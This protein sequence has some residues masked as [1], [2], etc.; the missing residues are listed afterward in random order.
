MPAPT[1]YE[2]RERARLD[3][4][5]QSATE[6][7]LRAR[8]KRTYEDSLNDTSATLPPAGQA[9]ATKPVDDADQNALAS[10]IT[11]P[12][13][14]EAD[15]VQQS[16]ALAQPPEQPA[17]SDAQVVSGFAKRLLR[18]GADTS[19]PG[20]GQA[21]A[22]GYNHQLV[23]GGDSGAA[24]SESDHTAD[25]RQRN[26][27]LDPNVSAR[28]AQRLYAGVAPPRVAVTKGGMIPE[29]STV[30][31]TKGPEAPGARDALDDAYAEAVRGAGGNMA[32]EQE[33]DQRLG[34]VQ[35][36]VSK[37]GE[38]FATEGQREAQNASDKLSAV[39][40]DIQKFINN[41]AVPVET[42]QQA[43][44]KWGA[45]KKIAFVLA[46]ALAGG[47][48]AA[49][50]KHDNAFLDSFN[51]FLKSETDRQAAE[52][53]QKEG[54]AE[55]SK[56]VYWMMHAGFKDDD[57]A[58]AATRAL[59]YQALES[60]LKEA[61]IKY[62]I[63]TSGPR[64]KSLLSQ[65]DTA[66]AHELEQL[67]KLSGA[68]VSQQESQR[69]VP[70]QAV[71]V[72]GGGM[73]PEDIAKDRAFIF[74]GIKDLKINEKA[75]DLNAMRSALMLGDAAKGG[76]LQ[77]YLTAHPSTSFA[78]IVA[79]VG[80]TPEG[81]QYLADVGAYVIKSGHTDFGAAFT[82]NEETRQNMFRSPELL[83][84]LYNRW[85]SDLGTDLRSVLRSAPSGH[86]YLTWEQMRGEE[87][88]MMNVPGSLVN[89]TDSKALPEAL[90]YPPE[91]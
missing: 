39:S 36:E 22:P 51:G 77:R 81:K 46:S 25:E 50:G 16:R 5:G 47:A 49:T 84:Q 21:P 32:A 4:A 55:A 26:V 61:A 54:Q 76:L 62:Q 75:K 85:S 82:P 44:Q 74:G 70:P 88:D 23:R 64:Y 71:V 69:Y 27:P 17:P 1:P 68:T 37:A 79:Q 2:L 18:G 40:S 58:R 14:S 34:R 73:K 80:T 86:G 48:G 67:A 63:D 28:A 43:M 7:E 52:R 66:R 30:Q 20:A 56:S 87:R 15:L 38:R 57:Q 91:P 8:A 13:D 10:Q 90:P 53:K 6:D 45:D 78:D 35:S 9:L 12:K 11:F 33:N 41:A 29:R 42:P 3:Y 60:R 24:V 65:I 89:T 72:G 83:P 59:Y 31:I 19:E